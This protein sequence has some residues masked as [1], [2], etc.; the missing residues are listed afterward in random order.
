MG[1]ALQSHG[2]LG[3]T[4][5]G[6]GRCSLV[7]VLEEFRVVDQADEQVAS[8]IGVKKERETDFENQGIRRCLWSDCQQGVAGLI[9]DFILRKSVEVHGPND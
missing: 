6:R 9:H 5:L 2:R 1:C 7:A 8:R 4:R 3:E